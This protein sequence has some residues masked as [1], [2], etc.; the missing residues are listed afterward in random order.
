[1]K[2][3]L[4]KTQMLPSN[5]IFRSA[6]K[7]A[8]FG[9]CMFGVF[10]LSITIPA[11]FGP[12]TPIWI[13]NA[14]VVC[15]VLSA[16]E[17][18]WIF[19]FVAAWHA[20]F[21]ASLLCGESFRLAFCLSASNLIGVMATVVGLRRFGG[22]AI[23]PA[24]SGNLAS[25][26]LIAGIAAPVMAAATAALLLGSLN[27]P[28]T[29]AILATWTASNGLGSMIFIPLWL[30]LRRAH[31]HI[32][33]RPVGL[34]GAFSV[35]GLAMVC[36]WVFSTGKPYAF[37]IPPALLWVVFE[38]ELIGAAVGVLIIF[39]SA[40]AAGLAGLGPFGRELGDVNDAALLAQLF[41][42][43]ITL[44]ALPAATALSQ[45]RR[46]RMQLAESEARY[47]LMADSSR[48]VLL[49][50]DTR[51]QLTFVSAGVKAVGY[52]PDD[53]VGRNV[54]D[55][56]HPE[57]REQ[58][59]HSLRAAAAAE[60]GQEVPRFNEFRVLDACGATIWL[61]GNPAAI[62]DATGRPIGFINM[63]RDV[64]Q[65]RAMEAELRE[66]HAAA[67]AAAQVKADFLANMSHEL[68]TPLTSV[69]GFTRLAL[70]GSGLD[71]SARH[72]IEKAANAGTALLAI[73]N[74]IL[75]FSALEQGAVSIQLQP[76]SPDRLLSEAISL[77]EG[78]AARKS[79]HLTYTQTGLP[80]AVELDPGRLR[81]ILLNLLGNAVKFSDQG[82]VRL[83]AEWSD[84]LLTLR[85]SDQGPGISDE[86]QALLFRRFSQIDGTSTRRYGGTGLGLAIS[87]GLLDAMRGAVEVESTPGQGSRFT[88]TLPARSVEN[89][90]APEVHTPLLSAQ[91]LSGVAPEVLVAD[92]HPGNREFVRAVLQS[93]GVSVFEAEN[94]EE[95]LALARLKRFDL[96]LMDLRMPKLDGEATVR[97]LRQIS[98]PNRM[99]P[100]LAFSAG[101]DAPGAAA[102]LAAGFTGDLS[103]P[104]LPVDLLRAVNDYALGTAA[105]ETAAG[106]TGFAENLRDVL[107]PK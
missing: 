19:M 84:N 73:I 7:V 6:V 29:W 90:C 78:E 9:L 16:P 1:M 39:A 24:S 64:T 41:I 32:K 54:L 75:D 99:T 53:L 68:R 106:E 25:L 79:L 87:R 85:V 82:E 15:C 31:D 97:T 102:R 23:D 51:G 93:Q 48:D 34:S 76:V 18:L 42:A 96:I 91:K 104:T 98:G 72:Y 27:R 20:D 107:A 2:L 36:A 4:M 3:I 101:V 67:E 37:L 45:M 8:G 88:V 66:A 26:I 60:P 52:D 30:I 100:I 14:V 58:A 77:F 80:A 57:D 105:P 13:A 46:L 35:L 28:E 40:V 59:A 63:L 55:Y 92:D 65:R 94:G 56:F 43:S 44:T 69:I 47:R 49:G 33:E 21:F 38:L 12:K 5:K 81:Q 95:A 17:P 10:Y 22:R 103:K 11:A 86:Q 62:R 74:D 71:T 61:E 50:Y 70:D 83:S 89:A